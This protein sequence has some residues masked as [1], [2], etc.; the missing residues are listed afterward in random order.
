MNIVLKALLF[1]FGGILVIGAMLFLPAGTLDYWQ[2]WVY[3]LTVFVPMLGVLVYFLAKDPDFLER[4]F[5]TKEKEKAQKAVQKIGSLLFL[6]G[7]LLPAFG[8]G[9]GW[10]D[11]PPAVSLA[12]DAAVLLGYCIVFAVFRENSFAGR[13]IRV[14]KGQKVVSTGLYSIVRHPMYVGMTVLCLAT[15]VALGLYAA[16]VPFLLWLPLLVLRIRNEEEVL[17]RE[18]KGYKEYCRKVRWRLVPGVW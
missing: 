6:I 14:E 5:K 17:K 3:M 1:Y 2:A 7:F 8:R 16:V 9:W 12:A 11:V 10:L 4:R 18:L 13:T 15:P